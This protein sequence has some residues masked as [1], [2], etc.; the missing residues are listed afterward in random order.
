MDMPTA[1]PLEPLTRRFGSFE[2]KT[3]G[4]FSEPSKLSTKSTVSLLMSA[5]SSSAIFRSLHS[6]YLIA[7]ASSPSTDPKLP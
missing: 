1:I 7:A 2:G 4:S 6:V 3:L 5:S